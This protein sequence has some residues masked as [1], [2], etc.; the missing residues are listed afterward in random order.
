MAVCLLFTV[1]HVHLACDEM[2]NMAF[3]TL[4]IDQADFSLL[5][6]H[7]AANSV[8]FAHADRVIRACDK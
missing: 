1:A 3:K 5:N 7:R 8:H 4:V 6:Q 2:L